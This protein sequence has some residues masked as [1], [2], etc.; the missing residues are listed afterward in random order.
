LW[1]ADNKLFELHHPSRLK[2]PYCRQISEYAR[3]TD[4][5]HTGIIGTVDTEG[6]HQMAQHVPEIM[7]TMEEGAYRNKYT[8]LKQMWGQDDV[9]EIARS[10]LIK[11]TAQ[12]LVQPRGSVG[13]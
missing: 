6:L 1:F 4:V 9:A 7:E 10:M 3:L 11:K 13:E 12:N 5:D 2:N 8:Q